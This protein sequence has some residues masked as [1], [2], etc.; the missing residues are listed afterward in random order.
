MLLQI[1]GTEDGATLRECATF[2][3]ALAAVATTTPPADSYIP[4]DV[5]GVSRE[6][7]LSDDSL[8]EI[9]SN[10]GTAK[11]LFDTADEP[12]E[13]TTEGDTGYDAT[14][15]P[16]D[17]RFCAKAK[18][19]F[20][21]SGPMKGQWKK[22]KGVDAAAY[23]AWHASNRPADESPEQP[24]DAAAA[25]GGTHAETTQAPSITDPGSLMAWV[26]E[27]Q[28][29]GRLTSADLDAAYGQLGLSMGDIF[30]PTDPTVVARNVANIHSILNA[31]V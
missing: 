14:G 22:R 18:D 31:K 24:V 25:F 3:T 29:A 2:I 7:P 12:E 21:A 8:T 11:S 5:T 15:V 10:A 30:P 13:P 27:H 16:F 26:S 1:D 17:A 20:Y 28:V 19:P 4:A 23:D 9:E 6:T